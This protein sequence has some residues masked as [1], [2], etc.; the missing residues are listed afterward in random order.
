M[1]VVFDAIH[2]FYNYM[3]PRIST[4]VHCVWHCLIIQPNEWEIVVILYSL[5]Y[6]T[7]LFLLFSLSRYYP[8]VVDEIL[9]DG[10]CSVNFEGYNQSEVTQVRT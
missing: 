2:D 8:C 6:C 10:T 5:R 3:T 9:E 4:Y 7:S 1:C